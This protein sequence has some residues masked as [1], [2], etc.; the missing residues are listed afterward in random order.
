MSMLLHQGEQ[1]AFTEAV[2]KVSGNARLP[3]ILYVTNYRIVFEQDVHGGLLRGRSTRTVLDTTLDHVHNAAVE[4]GLLGRP[5]VRIET[6]M[7][8]FTFKTQN[9]ANWVQAIAS[10]KGQMVPHAFAQRQTQAPVVVNVQQAAAPA[11]TVYLHCTHCG[12]L[13]GSGS[14]HC[15]SCGARL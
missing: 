4:R 10:T 14:V 7:G 11:P 13:A 15:T 9:A 1:V 8:A 6:S 5:A 12:S 2:D 3:G